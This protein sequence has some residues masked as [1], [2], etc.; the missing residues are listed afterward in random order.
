MLHRE[1]LAETLA[2]FEKLQ[3]E[4]REGTRVDGSHRPA[5]R[6]ER[7]AVTSQGYLTAGLAARIEE[8]QATLDL[9]DSVPPTERTRAV[10]GALVATES[11]EGA[12]RHW[13]ILPGADGQTVDGPEGPVVVV[14]PQSPVAR[15]LFGLEEG[16]EAELPTGTVEIV[17]VA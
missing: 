17:S 10:T 12:H 1:R 11:E 14:S 2:G 13:M 4:A 3:A 16:D 15:A 7:G 9:M 8:L 5:T 6:G